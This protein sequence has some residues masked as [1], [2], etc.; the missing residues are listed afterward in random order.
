MTDLPCE[1]K[2]AYP[3]RTFLWTPGCC[4]AFSDVPEVK[5]VMTRNHDQGQVITVIEGNVLRHV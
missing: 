1:E 2:S 5:S 4:G 3:I